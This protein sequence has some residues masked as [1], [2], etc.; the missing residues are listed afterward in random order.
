MKVDSLISNSWRV[1]LA[2]LWVLNAVYYGSLLFSL[3][4]ADGKK[5][6][7]VKKLLLLVAQVFIALKLDEVVDWSLVV[8]LAPYFTYEVLNLLE[9]VT[10][11]VLGH[12]MLVNDSVGASFSETA[13]IEEERHMLV[14][15]VVR[16]TVMTLLRITQALLVGM[17]ADGSLDGTNWW[18]VM[19]PVW[20]LVVYLC[21]Y[22]VKKYMN[23]TSAHRL[24]DAVFTAG[25]ILVLVAPFFLLADRLEGKKMPLFDI[26]MPWMLLVRV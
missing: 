15:A 1:V 14:K 2:P 24:M 22:P 20:I 6:G 11:G 19:T 23:S 3:V 13:S 25:I 26:F 21:W 18:R 5:Y 7:F 4:F 10:A 17:K 12:Q 9:T 8:V 16:K